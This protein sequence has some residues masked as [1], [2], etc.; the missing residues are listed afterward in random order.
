[1][2]ESEEE[3]PDESEEMAEESDESEAPEGSEASEQILMT[4][5]MILRSWMS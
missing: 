1:M 2:D 4:T 3:Y 5:S